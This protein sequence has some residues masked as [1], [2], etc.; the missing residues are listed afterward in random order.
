MT[1]RR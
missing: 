1:M